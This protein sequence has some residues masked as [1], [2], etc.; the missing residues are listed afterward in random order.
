[1]PDVNPKRTVAEL[2]ALRALTADDGG[3]RRVAWTETWLEARRWL[4]EKAVRLGLD[5]R[6]DPAG[7]LWCVLHG[8]SDRRL[9]LG[10]HMDSVPGGGWLD[11]CLDLLAGLEVIRRIADEHG[12]HP[13]VTV[14]LVDWADEEGARFGRSVFGSSA[15]AGSLV[16]D[17][18]RHR[19]DR[20]GIRFEDALR[21]CGVELDQAPEAERELAN[22]AAYL[23]LHIEQGPVLL[24]RG[25]PLGVVA[26]TFGV[27]RHVLTF[28]GQAAHAGST[29]MDR[30]R[31]ALLAAARM[32]P[33]LYVMTRRHGG[34]STIG[35]CV[36]RPGIVT[37]VVEE[38][39]ITLDQRHL[40]AD[41][42]AALLCHAREA[43]GRF[44][45]E[46]DVDVHWHPLLSIEP[47]AFHPELIALAEE[48]VE[49]VAGTSHRLPSG[50]LH[51]AS[52]IARAGIPSVMLF[53][54]SLHGISHSTL[55]DSRIEDIEKAVLALDLLARKTMAW[56]EETLPV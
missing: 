2:E 48:A 33:E 21:H 7:N 25:L 45:S 44:A 42:L 36:T 35:S 39:D 29:P 20:D 3:A 56:I 52:E 6:L 28:R 22:V 4:T 46:A 19:T 32:S 49:H 8:R 34:V 11:G 54:R 1:M 12:G 14:C 17:D 50:P 43:S 27:E 9:V 51:D 47:V 16:V 30:R 13:P 41:G 24:D 23:E 5:T 40:D 18:E 55:E 26:G 10:G 31:D 37:S 15:A 53:V 38:C